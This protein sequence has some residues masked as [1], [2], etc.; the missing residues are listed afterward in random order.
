MKPRD[1]IY[2]ASLTL[3]SGLSL[4]APVATDEVPAETDTYPTVLT[5][6]R[7]RQSLQDVPGSVTVITAETLRKFA[8]RSIPDALRLVP[9]MAVTQA[10]GTDFRINYHGTNVLVP[11]RMN[12]LI[13]GVSVY[14]PLF[15]RVD[16]T[17]LP[18]AVDDID[19]IEVTRGPNS[20][21][22]GPNSLLAIINIISRH[23]RDVER[24][25]AS[26]GKGSNG[27][28]AAT[29]RFGTQIGDIDM[30]LT[31]N[32]DRDGGYDTQQRV[33]T[34]HDSLRM[35]RANFRAV[36]PFGQATTLDVNAGYVGGTK[37]VPGVDSGGVTYPDMKPQDS[38]LSAT[39]THSFSPTHQLQTRAYIWSDVI[40]QSW[41]TCYPA[42]YF[43]PELFP[44]YRVNPAYVNAI[45]TGHVPSG[46]TA[47][48][49]ALAA[50]A[51]LAISN[52][53]ASATSPVCSTADQNLEQRR[54]DL[55]LQDTYVVSE[56][57]RFAAGAGLRR[58]S[59]LSTTYL[60]AEVNDS[61]YRAF[62]NLEYRPVSELA[63]NLGAYAE[64]DEL[65]GT[66]FSP[67]VSANYRLS[68]LQT[69]R[70]SWTRG[71]RTPDVQEQ[72]AN[73]TY[74]VNDLT[75]PLNGSSVARLF[76]SAQSPGGLSSERIRSV[77]VGYL[78][79]IPSIGLLLDLKA[80]RDELSSLISEKLQ[81]SAFRP[82]NN[83]AVNLSGV[84]LQAN[85]FITT[86]WSAFLNYAYL[87]NHSA[88][89]QLETTQY[90]RHSGSIGTWKALAAGWS[91]SLAYFGAAGDGLGQSSY[92]RT[93][94]S[95]SKRFTRDA[96]KAELTFTVRRLDNQ[97]QTYFRDFGVANTLSA[98]YDSRWHVLGQLKASF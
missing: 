68:D 77:E 21:A 71:T 34:D 47:T 46:G 52:L 78:L 84:E 54:L 14:Q 92:G 2:L 29:V 49:N 83:G 86:D 51:I 56:Q 59:G 9:G 45:L 43:L 33:G 35:T 31:L 38:Y 28:E 53:G 67:R 87:D 60:G 73:W 50:A 62:G 32:H 1:L 16:W 23:P 93:D 64:H 88:T 82:T 10:S 72:R 95:I 20:A 96:N 98:G 70:F 80:F 5:P 79:N 89:N 36:K 39:L 7:L 57:T 8:I 90:S 66:S 11:R 94:L 15:A 19:R 65:S 61:V 27:V 75:P 48:D 81:L 40:N 74:T 3:M 44:L 58:H 30:R 69:L 55:E 26:V 18:I 25:F 37:E 97:Q 24:A 91:A 6:T 12:V 76:Q 13:D 63:F 85:A 17:N 41:R 4:A 22:Y 42:A